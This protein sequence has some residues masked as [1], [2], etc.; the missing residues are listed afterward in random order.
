MKRDSL[1]IST[2]CLTLFIRDRHKENKWPCKMFDASLVRAATSQRIDSAGWRRTFIFFYRLSLENLQTNL[3]VFIYKRHNARFCCFRN[4][5]FTVVSFPVSSPCNL[6]ATWTRFPTVIRK[7][8]PR[9]PDD[10]NSSVAN[11]PIIRS[12]IYDPRESY[13]LYDPWA[14]S[15]EKTIFLSGNL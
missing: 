13:D 6:T 5:I 14:V 2:V 11:M 7:I 12:E 3:Q 8:F 15:R 9:S 4:G 10:N 1:P